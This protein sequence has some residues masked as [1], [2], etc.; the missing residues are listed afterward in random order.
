MWLSEAL[1]GWRDRYPDVAVHP[2]VI[3]EHPVAGLVLASSAQYLLVVGTAGHHA[4]PGALYTSN[5]S[6][7]S[8]VA[9]NSHGLGMSDAIR[10][11]TVLNCAPRRLVVLA[12]E[13]ADT[14][15]GY[16]LSR[17]V[18]A[19]IPMLAAAVLHEVGASALSLIATCGPV[20]PV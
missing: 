3:R 10:L 12:V 7:D 17:P 6:A 1:A 16:G 14:S 9:G 19:A 4:L 5:L 13:A 2:E 8:P 20:C 15:V 11:A 18:M